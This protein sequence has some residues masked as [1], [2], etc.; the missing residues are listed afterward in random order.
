[1]SGRFISFEGGE[2]AG[3]STQVL[4]LAE[5]LASRSCEVVATREPG[6]TAGAEA[7]RTLFVSGEPERWDAVTEVLLVNAA[8]ADHVARL[9]RPALARGA[10]VVCDRYVDST[11][12]YQ[13][14][15]KG[16]PRD[17]LIEQHRFATGNL[18]PDLTLVLDLPPEEGATRAAARHGGATRF[19][20]HDA[21]FHARVAA[22]FRDVAR[23]DPARVRII[24]AR[25]DAAS[26]A[27]AVFA[28]VLPLLAA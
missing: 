19:E 12:A 23:D 25:C 7:I 22:A 16:V 8:R 15:G 3:K 1:M 26:V 2:G 4:L 20:A 9:I 18:W 27:A 28:E 21:A 11:L 24:D 17:L 5:T 14:A 10:W 13:G 6:G